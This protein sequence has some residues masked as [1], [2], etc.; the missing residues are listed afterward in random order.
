[1]DES[2]CHQDIIKS[3]IEHAK[4]VVRTF[5]AA[6]RAARALVSIPVA[7]MSTEDQALVAIAKFLKGSGLPEPARLV[8][9]ARGKGEP[10]LA[11]RLQ[12]LG[13]KLLSLADAAERS[14]RRSEPGDRATGAW[15]DQ[16]LRRFADQ[17]LKQEAHL[18]EAMS[19]RLATSLRSAS[20]TSTVTGGASTPDVASGVPST[21]VTPTAMPLPLEPSPH[22]VPRETG[23]VNYDPDIP[24]EYRDDLDP[25]YRIRHVTEQ[26]LMEEIREKY[27][28][29]LA[30]APE[31]MPWAQGLIPSKEDAVAPDD[32]ELLGAPKTDSLDEL[33]G[34]VAE[35]PTVSAAQSTRMVAEPE[36]LEH[37]LADAIK[38]GVSP[39]HDGP[40][41]VPPTSVPTFGAQVPAVPPAG[42]S[43]AGAAMAMFP[44][45][46]APAAEPEVADAVPKALCCAKKERKDD[47]R[48]AMRYP[49]SGD[50]FYPV[51]LDGVVYDSFNLRIIHERDR[52]GFEE[53]KD[54]PIR[55]N[56]IVAGR[57]Q[58]LE[59]LGSA[60][61]SR[62]VQCLDLETNRMVC[63]KIINN[64][65]D[66]FDQSLD[67]IK[68]LRLIRFNTESVD[69]K[70]CLGLVD[71]F[72]HKEHLIIVTE[73][74]RDNLYEFSKYNRQACEEPYFTLGR[75]Q[76]IAHQ[77][78]V[79]L[80]LSTANSTALSRRLSRSVF[81]MPGWPWLSLLLGV[82]GNAPEVAT[83]TGR[84]RG[85]SEGRDGEVH[86]FRGIPYAEAPVGDLRWRPPRRVKPWQGLRE[87][88]SY[89]N[90]SQQSPALL[91]TLNYRLNVFGFLG[92]DQLRDRDE[93]NGSTGNYG[94][95]DQR[96]ALHWVQENIGAFG[97]DPQKVTLWGHSSGGVDVGLHLMTPSSY[98]L[99][100]S[101]ILQS[102]GLS[103]WC[104]QHMARKE[105]WFQRLMGHTHCRD[106]DCLVGLSADELLS[107]Y[108]AI[109][110]GRC[111]RQLKELGSDPE[112]PWSPSIDG[113]ELSAHPWDLLKQ[114]KGNQVP[115]LI[116]ITQDDGNI[117]LDVAQ[118]LSN[119]DFQLLFQT[120]YQSSQ[121]QAELYS[122]ESHES[123]AGPNGPS[124]GWWSALRA[125]T[126][127]NYF[128]PAH[129]SRRSL[130]T[131]AG[132]APGRSVFGYV[133][134]AHGTTGIAKHSDDLPFIFMDLPEEASSEERQ[135]AS[136]MA[137]SWY[138]FAAWGRPAAADLWPAQSAEAAPIVKFQV[139]SKGGNQVIYVDQAQD[140]RCAFIMDWLNRALRKMSK[141]E[142]LPSPEKAEAEASVATCDDGV[143]TCAGYI[144]QLYL[145]HADLKPENILIKSYSRCEVKVIDFGSSCFVDDCL[146]NYVQSR[147]YRAPEVILGLPYDQKIDLWSLGCIIAELWSG[148]VLFQNDSVQSLLARIMGILG[149]FPSH[150]LATGRFVPQYF[151][152]DGRLF[153]EMDASSMASGAERH[154]Q[155][156]VPKRTSLRQRM[157]TNDEAFLDFLSSLLQV[158]PC[159]RPTASEALKHP[160]LSAGRYSDGFPE[161][162]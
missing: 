75:L 94:L 68:L 64:N 96:M 62:A 95:Q 111:C 132:T 131:G 10:G 120:K 143:D 52:T 151:T 29:A 8:H 59:Y 57:Y 152:Q 25:G 92:S 157:R 85:I 159:L 108:M 129:F 145:I 1:M 107:A 124:E 98:G 136:E 16:L 88:S 69:D 149:P 21:A 74:L 37:T 100:S 39:V 3:K 30:M 80:E 105:L 50:G 127:K 116:G 102:G 83:P 76:R 18:Q 32:D 56:S 128:C 61:F 115:I 28:R 19:Q 84:L 147:S 9:N 113:V 89:G 12:E 106:V 81:A 49:E 122:L 77:V 158:D 153:R 104:A 33:T 42:D 103:A 54:F 73:L 24:E 35:E 31:L 114:G 58:V 154:M 20:V 148:F 139:A 82:S 72:Y 86:V 47:G 118:N 142:T 141:A 99:Y 11:V 23:D 87:A 150:L 70:N 65:K 53:T 79:A 109:P 38:H 55:P 67:E 26:E 134:A 43:V 6:A 97:G 7:T 2:K 40:A 162:L 48:P 138:H 144:H 44:G 91:I 137:M 156:L 121:A 66:F 27:E 123:P 78:L 60:A 51:D 71:Y 160:F 161:T 126:D 135:L 4:V 13:N 90:Q 133:F 93:R 112:M 36:T 117:L 63:M 155:L 14:S 119:K 110:D 140:Q 130:V 125:V 146:T 41:E 46:D 5:P 15:T 34:G 17:A 22:Y 101:A 45:A